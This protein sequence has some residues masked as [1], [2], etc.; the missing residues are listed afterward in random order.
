MYCRLP[1]DSEPADRGSPEA[2]IVGST[3][4]TVV[5]VVGCV[6][7]LLSKWQYFFRDILIALTYAHINRI[8]KYYHNLLMPV[9]CQFASHCGYLS[10]AYL[11]IGISILGER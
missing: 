10:L 2:L 3:V 6:E 7:S 5:L 8:V 9:S 11:D 1:A 4:T